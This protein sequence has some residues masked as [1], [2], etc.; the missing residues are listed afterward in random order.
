M[1]EYLEDLIQRIVKSSLIILLT[2]ILT[3]GM[4]LLIGKFARLI[5]HLFGLIL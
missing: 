2:L 1:S 4:A 3:V 5:H